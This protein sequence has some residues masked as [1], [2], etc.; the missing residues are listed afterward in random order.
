MMATSSFG[1]SRGRLWGSF[2]HISMSLHWPTSMLRRLWSAAPQSVLCRS[3][4]Q[5]S[6]LNL[7]FDLSVISL[8]FYV[9]TL[10]II[11][12]SYYCLQVL[13]YP[14]IKRCFHYDYLLFFNA[15]IRILTVIFFILLILSIPN[16]SFHCVL[17]WSAVGCAK[18]PSGGTPGG[19]RALRRYQYLHGNVRR[20]G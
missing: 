20:R 12:S 8:N 13:F 15:T 1:P 14:L 5:R 17:D 3:A 9:R 6:Q 19:P 7:A 2:L 4:W 11:V 18:W 10:L 16:C